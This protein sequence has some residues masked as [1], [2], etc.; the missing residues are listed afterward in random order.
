MKTLPLL[1]A[2]IALLLAAGCQ[3]APASPQAAQATTPTPS[4][5]PT[6]TL[7]LAHY[8]PWYQTPEVSGY[9][10]WHWEM[11]HFN[12]DQVDENGRPQIASHYLPLTGP[13]DSKDDAVL[14][15]QT[16]LMKLSGIDGVI[17][18][19]YGSST[20]A[21]YGI[22]NQATA[23]LFE[24]VQKAGLLFA[25]C[26]ED[27][28]IK[29]MVAQKQLSETPGDPRSAMAQGEADL[30]YLQETWF[31]QPAY[32]K[33]QG[34]PVLFNFGPQYFINGADWETLFMA[35]EARPAL[36]TLDGHFV[37]AAIAT[38][39]WPPMYLS[40]G[41]VLYL[42]SLEGYLNNYYQKARRYPYR[43]AGAFPGFHDI[44]KEAGVGESYGYLE[45]RDGETFALT[46]DEAIE[47][48]PDVI[49]LITWND[50]GEGTIIEPT[51][52]FGYRYLE[53]LQAAQPRLGRAEFAYTA[54]DLRLPL[55]IF[56]L[57]KAHTDAQ[58]NAL[59]D[60]VVALLLEGQTGEARQKLAQMP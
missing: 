14:E 4:A 10:G 59:L 26:Y 16:L 35:L 36:V 11:D 18:D 23:R 40:Q 30:L 20:F 7:L 13:Y 52:E 54:D 1:I 19:W 33:Y 46:L 50:Y 43:V 60:E 22:I 38:F 29:H 15:Y 12:P 5:Q 37:S 45:A 53:M 34:Q 9:W 3:A 32:L 6:R 41:G 17:V 44:Y 56:Q 21:D 51:A 48:S 58:T 55:Q 47:Q 49:Q 27:Q 39:P 28:T 57:R 24:H 8:M 25:I 31:N 2:G 42:P